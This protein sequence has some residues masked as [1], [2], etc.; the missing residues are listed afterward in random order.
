MVRAYRVTAAALRSVGLLQ[1]ARALLRTLVAVTAGTM[2]LTTQ[3][4]W[5]DLGL[6]AMRSV[7]ATISAFGKIQSGSS[8]NSSTCLPL[9]GPTVPS[10]LKSPR[11]TCRYKQPQ[12]AALTMSYS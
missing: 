4:S 2:F 10:D 5:C 8:R 1:Q 12:N 6:L 3:R 9:A 11:E 7:T